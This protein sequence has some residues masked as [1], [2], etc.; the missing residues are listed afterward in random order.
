VI[1]WLLLLLLL[2]SW[3]Y[4]AAASSMHCKHTS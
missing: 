3:V 4:L 2:R 1:T